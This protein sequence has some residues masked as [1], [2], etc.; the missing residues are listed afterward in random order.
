MDSVLKSAKFNYL[1]QEGVAESD[2]YCF[3]ALVEF[4]SCY[5]IRWIETDRSQTDEPLFEFNIV[6]KRKEAEK[7]YQDK[8]NVAMNKFYNRIVRHIEDLTYNELYS[9]YEIPQDP[10]GWY[11]DFYINNNG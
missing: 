1:N 3:I 6:E 5:E 10:V 11:G 2:F 8:L 7:E 9:D 4:N